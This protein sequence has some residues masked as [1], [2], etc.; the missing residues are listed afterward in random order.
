MTRPVRFAGDLAS[1]PTHGFGTR[2]LTWW[3]V[4]GFMLIEGTGFALAIAAYFFLMAQESQWP[5]SAPPPRLAWGV[6]TTVIILL[7]EIPNVWVKRA[8]ER[9]EL[10][11]TRIGLVVMSVLGLAALGTR[12][13]EFNALEIGWDRNAYGSIVWALLVLHTAHI[14]TDWIDTLVL[15]ALMFTVH[16]AEGRRFVDASENALYWHFVALSWLLIHVVLYWV[17]RL[18]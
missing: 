11:A 9:E 5:A 2:S 7:S 4:V 10:R 14:L 13:M 16:G 1:L 17:P 18:A 3:G 15:T 12:A 8:A 6:A